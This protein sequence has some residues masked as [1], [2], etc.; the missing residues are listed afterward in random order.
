MTTGMLWQCPC[1][2]GTGVRLIAFLAGLSLC[3]QLLAQDANYS[4]KIKP[5][6]L[7]LPTGTIRTSD[8][9]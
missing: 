1:V 9:L 7:G 8:R 2:R 6:E 3:I 5:Q 4:A